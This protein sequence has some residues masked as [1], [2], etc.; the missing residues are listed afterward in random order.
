MLPYLT[1]FNKNN[2]RHKIKFNLFKVIYV[3]ILSLFILSILK[4]GV[5]NFIKDG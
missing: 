3:L 1:L 2:E 4:F 5:T